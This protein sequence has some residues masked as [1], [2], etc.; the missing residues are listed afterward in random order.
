MGR[1]SF[2]TAIDG[3]LYVAGAFEDAASATAEVTLERTTQVHDPETEECETTFGEQRTYAY[4]GEKVNDKV[5]S[6]RYREEGDY[7][8]D[9]TSLTSLASQWYRFYSKG[10]DG[11]GIIHVDL[12]VK[13]TLY[14]GDGEV[15]ETLELSADNYEFDGL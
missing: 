7:R 4:Q 1:G 15:L 2:C 10:E 6:F 9:Y 11:Y 3:T 13:V 5:F 8:H 14:G 12:P